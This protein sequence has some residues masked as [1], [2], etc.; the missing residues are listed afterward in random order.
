MYKIL[1]ALTLAVGMLGSSYSTVNA[2]DTNDVVEAPSWPGKCA[3]FEAQYHDDVASLSGLVEEVTGQK[4]SSTNTCF[5]VFVAKHGNM[6]N[7][8]YILNGWAL[9]NLPV[10][11]FV[12]WE[13]DS[14]IIGGSSEIAALAVIDED[15]I[16]VDGGI[17]NIYQGKA[18]VDMVDWS[19]VHGGV[20]RNKIRFE[21]SRMNLENN[22]RVWTGT[23]KGERFN[24]LEQALACGRG[25]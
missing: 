24:D 22:T 20:F 7:V 23:C 19:T 14:Y 21:S 16:V 3:E 15:T 5:S 1:F 2:K 10:E 13:S 9:L 17:D 11:V 4:P 18:L 25:K 8:L 12:P 6:T